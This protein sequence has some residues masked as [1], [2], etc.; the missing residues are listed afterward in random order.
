MGK[1]N[2]GMLSMKFTLG[3][4]LLAWVFMPAYSQVVREVV[5]KGD[6]IIWIHSQTSADSAFLVCSKYLV[7]K[8]YSFESR[9]PDLG[10]V[11]TNEKSYAGGFHYKLN[12]VFF[13]NR[14]KIRAS[15][16]AMTLSQQIVWMD[17]FYAKAKG[18]LY[19][20]AFLKFQPDIVE[21]NSLLTNGKISYGKE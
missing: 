3:I 13:E 11:V 20:D 18:S 6:N 17:W 2:F 14:I 12:M 1:T 21:M 10:Q 5:A 16:Q 19:N 7:Q 15:A 8:R 4:I 9:D